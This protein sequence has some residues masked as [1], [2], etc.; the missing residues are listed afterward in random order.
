MR[1]KSMRRLITVILA[2]SLFQI[3][4]SPFVNAR[5]RQ[6]QPKSAKKPLI[7]HIKNE[8]LVDMCGC[9]F[10]QHSP[11]PAYTFLGDS[12][13]K[14]AWMNL[15][16][17]DIKLKLTH[18]RGAKVCKIGSRYTE[19]FKADGIKVFLVRIVNRLCIP[20]SS[21]CETTGYK[22]TITVSKDSRVESIKAKGQCGCL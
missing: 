21:E 19:T 22:V 8:E 7:G 17:E 16:G 14:F 13:G 2:M 4:F 5:A 18:F 20:Y 15:D 12:E 9:T 1:R 6:V 3:L 11:T 10:A